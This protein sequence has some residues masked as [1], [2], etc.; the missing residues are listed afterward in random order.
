MMIKAVL[1]S[2]LTTQRVGPKEDGNKKSWALNLFDMQDCMVNAL[3]VTSKSKKKL[4]INILLLVPHIFFLK[5]KH[6]R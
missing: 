1:L 4:E 6:W 2:Q 5:T 3:F